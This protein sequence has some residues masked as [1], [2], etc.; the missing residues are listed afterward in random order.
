VHGDDGVEARALPAA[1]EQF[2]VIE[3]GEVALGD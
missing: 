1:D 2:F 3:G